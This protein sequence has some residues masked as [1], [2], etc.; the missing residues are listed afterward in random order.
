M[1]VTI[2]HT[3]LS[4]FCMEAYNFDVNLASLS[5]AFCLL[6]T[7]GSFLTGFESALHLF[8]GGGYLNM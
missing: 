8:K 5:N 3:L 6:S 2:Q 1:T 4:F 7:G